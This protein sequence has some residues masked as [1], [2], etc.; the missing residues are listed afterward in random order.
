MTIENFV[1]DTII[2]IMM[3]IIIITI[4]HVFSTVVLIQDTVNKK[5]LQIVLT[6]TIRNPNWC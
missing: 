6:L 3:V 4:S 1:A 2:I 5:I